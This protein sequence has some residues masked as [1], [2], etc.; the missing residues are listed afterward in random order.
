MG[1]W[2]KGSQGPVIVFKMSGKFSI[3]DLTS[4]MEEALADIRGGDYKLNPMIVVDY[5]ALETTFPTTVSEM[6][7]LI[8]LLT[9]AEKGGR[10][11]VVIKGNFTAAEVFPISTAFKTKGFMCQVGYDSEGIVKL[12]QRLFPGAGPGW[13]ELIYE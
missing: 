6:G 4:V 2:K 9:D 13:E 1:E 12:I 8:P 10:W 3:D 11:P 7:R 5:S